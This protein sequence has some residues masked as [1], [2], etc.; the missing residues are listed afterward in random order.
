MDRE[1]VIEEAA[2]AMWAANGP[3]E[4]ERATGSEQAEHLTL[5]SA[6]LAVFEKA[7]TADD[8]REALMSAID[9]SSRRAAVASRAADRVT[10]A[11]FHRSVAPT[12]DERADAEQRWPI[13]LNYEAGDPE[14][15]LLIAQR[16]AYML[17]RSD[18]RT[19]SE[20]PEPQGEPSDAT[21]AAAVAAYESAWGQS[22]SY[23]LRAA[24]IAAGGVR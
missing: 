4:W 21:V 5:A 24:L 6:A 22:H 17:G 13:P 1:E 10:A 19:R 16:Q 2:K 3:E 20:I 15:T 12:D 11:G 23:K 9:P 8:E 7:H 18:A 14:H